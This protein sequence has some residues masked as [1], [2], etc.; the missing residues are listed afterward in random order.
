MRCSQPVL[1]EGPPLPRGRRLS[2]P[3][4]LFFKGRV[5]LRVM[6]EGPDREEVDGLAMGLAGEV[7]SVL[8]LSASW[9]QRRSRL[10]SDRSRCDDKR[11][12]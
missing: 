5:L 11:H 2:M 8:A 3:D 10:R 1:H 6:V 12:T 4:P 9:V 7:A